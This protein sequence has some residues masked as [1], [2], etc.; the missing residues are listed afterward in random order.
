M[1]ERFHDGPEPMSINSLGLI[2]GND[3][4]IGTFRGWSVSGQEMH[5]YGGTFVG[6]IEVLDS[7][8]IFYG[9][10]EYLSREREGDTSTLYIFQFAGVQEIITVKVDDYFGE[11]DWIETDECN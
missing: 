2:F 6:T 8:A 7:A 11:I 10:F 5:V 4:A 1:E 9:C 3:S